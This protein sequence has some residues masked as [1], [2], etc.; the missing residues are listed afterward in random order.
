MKKFFVIGI[1]DSPDFHFAKEVE[2][3]LSTARVFSGGRRHHELVSEQL[4]VDAQWID[5]TV[6]LDD[7]FR[8]YSAVSSSLPPVI[9]CSLVLPIPSVARCRMPRSSSIP[10]STPFR[11]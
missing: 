8:Q 11:P 1:P 2:E 10:G 6:P 3:L 4:S 9:P 5:I 7:V